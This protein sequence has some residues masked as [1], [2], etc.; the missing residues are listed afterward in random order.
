MLRWEFGGLLRGENVDQMRAERQMPWKRLLNARYLFRRM[1]VSVEDGSA[2]DGPVRSC[3][4]GVAPPRR[5]RS[6]RRRGR[7]LAE[8]DER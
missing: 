4:D 7:G 8:G 2:Q 3:R 1:A 6:L 5:G